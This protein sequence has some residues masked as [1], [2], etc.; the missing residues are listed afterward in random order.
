MLLVYL[1]IYLVSAADAST[2]S[3]VATAA[4]TPVKAAA[5]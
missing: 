2:A 1:C 3:I 4:S 5:L